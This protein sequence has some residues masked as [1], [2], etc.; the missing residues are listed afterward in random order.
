LAIG[1]SGRGIS[2]WRLTHRQAKLALSVA[3]RSD[4]QIV[5]Y[6]DVALLASVLK[7]TVLEESLRQAYL[8]PLEGERDGGVALRETLRAYLAAGR[9]V[10]SSAAAL[11]V[12]RQTVKR[13]VCLAEERIGHPL[14]ERAV[15][16]ETALRLTQLEPFAATNVQRT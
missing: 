16:I 1:Q 13:R 15:E 14:S 6:S 2:G 10:S 9:N 3:L 4:D 8:A 11:G 7:D 12:S 5:S